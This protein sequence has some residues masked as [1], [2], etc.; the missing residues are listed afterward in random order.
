MKKN[1]ICV[2]VQAYDCMRLVKSGKQT[3]QKRELGANNVYRSQLSMFYLPVTIL[4]R[5]R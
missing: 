1:K 5:N 3:Y 4:L 2:H